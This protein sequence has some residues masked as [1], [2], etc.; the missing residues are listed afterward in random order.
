M[1]PGWGQDVGKHYQGNHSQDYLMKSAFYNTIIKNFYT[2]N[3]NCFGHNIILLA[4]LQSQFKRHSDMK[5][6]HLVVEAK[7]KRNKMSGKSCKMRKFEKLLRNL[8]VLSM[9]HHP[10]Q[11]LCS[12]LFFGTMR[13]NVVVKLNDS[14]HNLSARESLEILKDGRL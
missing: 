12:F 2:N 7:K 6:F 14:F 8:S 13:T 10:T 5:I 4:F 3:K 9:E 1:I 11:V